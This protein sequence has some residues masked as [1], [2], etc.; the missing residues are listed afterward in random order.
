MT[1]RPS[2]VRLSFADIRVVTLAEMPEGFENAR[3]T[4][5]QDN[6]LIE[7]VRAAARGPEGASLILHELVHAMLGM[8]GLDDR[9]GAKLEEDVAVSLGHQLAELI[10]RNPGLIAWLQ[11][12]LK[13]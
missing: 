10:R 2:K 4:Y 3:A 12:E 13:R 6:K 11:Q 9:L 1:R 8:D 7:V 5:D